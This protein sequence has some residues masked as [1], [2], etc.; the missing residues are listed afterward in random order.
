[1]RFKASER[2]L[3]EARKVVDALGKLKGSKITDNEVLLAINSLDQWVARQ[4][5]IVRERVHPHGI[6][7][8]REP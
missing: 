8:M 6:V 4:P 5:A 3:H 1:M 2:Q 7:V